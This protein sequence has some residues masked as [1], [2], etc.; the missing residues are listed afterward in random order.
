MATY[1]TRRSFSNHVT[2]ET[3]LKY[4]L[5]VQTYKYIKCNS[6]SLRKHRMTQSGSIDTS[7]S[8]TYN[9]TETAW[10][11]S[12]QRQ[13]IQNHSISVRNQAFVSII[14]A[15]GSWAAAAPAIVFW[16]PPLGWGRVRRP[17]S[18]GIMALRP[19]PRPS[20]VGR[21]AAAAAIGATCTTAWTRPV[22]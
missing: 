7:K 14:R 21:G 5:F 11:K 13:E 18:R 15:T 17:G 12:S 2:Y 3:C 1:W 6:S 20:S 9:S 4:K 8:T 19:G 16:T 10:N 22:A